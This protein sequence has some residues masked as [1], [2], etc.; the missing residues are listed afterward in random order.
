MRPMLRLYE[1]DIVSF[2]RFA[3]IDEPQP[4]QIQILKSRFDPIK[5]KIWLR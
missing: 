2:L 5:V 3:G 1:I 4:Y